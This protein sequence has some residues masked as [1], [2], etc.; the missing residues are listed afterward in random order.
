MPSLGLD[1]LKRIGWPLDSRIS[2]RV[3]FFSKGGSSQSLSLSPKESW[4]TGFGALLKKTT[5]GISWF[6]LSHRY[7]KEWVQ[8][9]LGVEPLILFRQLRV[10]LWQIQAGLGA[11]KLDS[12]GGNLRRSEFGSRQQLPTGMPEEV[13][14]ARQN[15]VQQARISARW[16]LLEQRRNGL[17]CRG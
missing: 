10:Q 11:Q 3:P 15:M 2:T 1:P 8:C 13:A 16:V 17:E 6:V 9:V 5:H 12:C 14:R 4:V 7:A